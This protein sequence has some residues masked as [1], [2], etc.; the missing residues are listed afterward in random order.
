[1]AQRSDEQGKTRRRRSLPWGPGRSHLASATHQ[2]RQ[3][4]AALLLQSRVNAENHEFHRL[5]HTHR[6][7]KALILENLQVLTGEAEYG[8]PETQQTENGYGPAI[9]ANL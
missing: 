6:G 8:R 4:A 9:A 2:R 3:L 1:M 5:G 7:G